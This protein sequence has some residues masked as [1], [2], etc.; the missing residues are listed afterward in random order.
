[1]QRMLFAVTKFKR[2]MALLGVIYL[3]TVGCLYLVLADRSDKFIRDGQ[4]VQGTVEAVYLHHSVSTGATRYLMHAEGGNVALISYTY[5]GTTDTISSN[6]YRDAKKYHV[7]QKVD[8]VIQ[9]TP[10]HPDE[11]IVTVRDHT[12]LGMRL[13]PWG[14]LASAVI[15]TAWFGRDYLKSKRRHR[16][17]GQRRTPATVEA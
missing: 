12:I 9:A 2:V 8:L 10:G 6:P 17:G 3:A 11:A 14:F 13:I 15:M 7:G 5:D 1:V 4:I 16:V